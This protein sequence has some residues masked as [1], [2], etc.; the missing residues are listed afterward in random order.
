MAVVEPRLT[1]S[2]AARRHRR[3]R[4]RRAHPRARGR[5]L[6]LRLALHRRVLHAGDEPDPRRAAARLRGRRR[7]RGAHGR[8]PTPRRSP[9]WRSR[10]PSSGVNHAL[11]HA[12]GA[13]FG[14]AHGRAN[15]I[16]LPHVL[17]YNASLPRKFMPSPGVRHLRGAGQVRADVVR[18]RPRRPRRGGAP[19]APLRP[20]RRAARRGRA[21]RAP[22]RRWAST[23][24]E[25]ERALPDLARA[26][27]ADPSVRTNPRIPHGRRAARAARGRVRR[28]LAPPRRA[29]SHPAPLS[30]LGYR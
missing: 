24:A 12:V 21:C 28:P 4:R 16:F 22:W 20:R 23:R 27:F 3:H 15:A 1:L 29:L 19:R 9:A 7:P 30:G 17:R 2:H 14:I 5:R 10:T 11:A 8:W 25:F 13:R 26:A 6:D 18:P